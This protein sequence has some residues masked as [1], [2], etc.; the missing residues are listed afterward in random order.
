MNSRGRVGRGYQGHSWR[1]CQQPS[2]LTF[3]IPAFVEVQLT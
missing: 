3:V 2:W 1:E